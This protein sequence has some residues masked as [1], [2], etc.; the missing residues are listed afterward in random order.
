MPLLKGGKIIADPWLR[1]APPEDAPDA[2]PEDVPP[3][4]PLLVDYPCWQAQGSTLA[5]RPGQ[6]GILLKSDQSPLLIESDSDRFSLIALEFPVFRDGR[7]FSYARILRERM[8]YRGEIRAVGNV[9]RD[10]FHFMLR[11][12]FDAFEV[13]KAEDAAAW[14]EAVTEI[15]LAYQTAADN[16]PSILSLRPQRGRRKFSVPVRP[17]G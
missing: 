11:C 17:S 7:A 6:L 12:G 13:A 9:L 16:T 8:A 1:Y 5:S 15:S 14:N 3:D 2:P 4:S 10:Q